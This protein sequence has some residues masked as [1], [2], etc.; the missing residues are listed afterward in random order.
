MKITSLTST[1]SSLRSFFVL[2]KA[3]CQLF[4][5]SHAS[6]L[7]SCGL[8]RARRPRYVFV[9]P[10]REKETDRY[11]AMAL[12]IVFGGALG[13]LTASQVLAIPDGQLKTDVSCAIA[14]EG[15]IVQRLRLISVSTILRSSNPGYSSAYRYSFNTF[16]PDLFG[17]TCGDTND[18]CLCSNGT[19]SALVTCEQCMLTELINKNEPMPDPRA[20]STPALAGE[21]IF[22]HPVI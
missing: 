17:Q 18:A 6:F 4:C 16:N 1:S 8:L 9:L 10:N 22:L 13:N 11:V 20:G 14:I 7:R 12:N 15:G 2:W 21:T 3:H 19:V 5:F